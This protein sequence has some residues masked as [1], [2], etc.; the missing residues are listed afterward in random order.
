M[1]GGQVAGKAG[2]GGARKGAAPMTT[3]TIRA[4]ARPL[5]KATGQA[6]RAAQWARRAPLLPALVFLIVVTQLPFAATVVISFLRWNALDPTNRGFA[7]LDNYVAVF[8]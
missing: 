5:G 7:G 3:D 8:T 2:A 6:R 4:P 1:P